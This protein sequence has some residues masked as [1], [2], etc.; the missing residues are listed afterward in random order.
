MLGCWFSIFVYLQAAASAAELLELDDSRSPFLLRSPIPMV[1]ASVTSTDGLSG[2]HTDGGCKVTPVTLP[3]VSPVLS[4][5][6]STHTVGTEACVDIDV[7]RFE[8]Q[9]IEKTYRV[10]S[11]ETKNI[12]RENILYFKFSQS[13]TMHT[14]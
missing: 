6:N 12:Y 14:F 4:D 7:L 3:M 5:D 1:S 13:T 11:F 10:S 2:H 9:K 8:N